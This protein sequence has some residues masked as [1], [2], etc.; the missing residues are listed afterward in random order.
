MPRSD[1]L[2]AGLVLAIIA[3]GSTVAI[4]TIEF[5]LGRQVGLAYGGPLLAAV[6]SAVFATWLARRHRR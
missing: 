1:R 2:L 4:L 3:L 5:H 6:L